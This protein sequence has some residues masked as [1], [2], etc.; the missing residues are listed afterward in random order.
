MADVTSIP[1]SELVDDYYKSLMEAKA[2]EKLGLE[3]RARGNRHIVATIEEELK[4]RGESHRIG[5]EE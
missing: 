1:V 3:E 4:R 2:C 5:K